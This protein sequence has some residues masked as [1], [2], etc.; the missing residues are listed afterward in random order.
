MK[1]IGPSGGPGQILGIPAVPPVKTFAPCGSARP[2]PECYE[3]HGEAIGPS[4]PRGGG[5]WVLRPR[6]LVES[7]RIIGGGPFDVRPLTGFCNV[8]RSSSVLPRNPVIL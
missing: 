1:A 4:G 5:A 2:V 8:E 7:D 6:G 3:G